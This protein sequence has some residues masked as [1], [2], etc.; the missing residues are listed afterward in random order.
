ML[1]RNLSTIEKII[2]VHL[3]FDDHSEKVCTVKKNDVGRFTFRYDGKVVKETGTVKDI[4]ETFDYRINKD[5]NASACIVLDSSEKFKSE[6]YKISIVDLIDVDIIPQVECIG[7][8]KGKM[9]MRI[10]PE[11]RRKCAWRPLHPNKEKK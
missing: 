8:D 1:I 9:S 4:I 5:R 2:H 6:E 3:V 7:P 10:M 11:K